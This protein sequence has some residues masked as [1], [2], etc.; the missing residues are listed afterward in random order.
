MLFNLDYLADITS[1]DT[2]KVE[3]DEGG[4][5]KQVTVTADDKKGPIMETL[6]QQFSLS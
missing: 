5:L 4:F 1:D 6:L 3:L 2:F